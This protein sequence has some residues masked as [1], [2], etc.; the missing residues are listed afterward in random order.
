MAFLNTTT[1]FTS[2][3]NFCKLVLKVLK[4]SRDHRDHKS[5]H[6]IRFSEV[7]KHVLVK[8]K[9]TSCTKFDE[10]FLQILSKHGPL[11]NNALRANHA[12]YI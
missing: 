7:L 3:S 11:N 6:S 2:L 8:E 5:F 9:I 12:S 1:V 10:I 4:T